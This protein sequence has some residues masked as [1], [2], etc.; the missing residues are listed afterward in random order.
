MN[1]KK[2]P[3]QN[4]RNFL[5]QYNIFTASERKGI[6]ILSAVLLLLM[7]VLAALKFY[8]PQEKVVFSELDKT[9]KQFQELK[10]ADSIAIYSGKKTDTAISKPVVA[11]VFR[12][13]PNTLTD[14]LWLT[15]GISEKQLAVIR[16]YQSKGG[17][18]RTRGDFKKLYTISTE[19]YERLHP[20]IDLPDS[21]S[22]VKKV[23][24]HQQ[25]V[26][27]EKS[28]APVYM[29]A[30]LELEWQQLP[31]IG[32]G[33]AAA[34]VAYREKLGGYFHIEQLLDIKIINDTVLDVIKPYLIVDAFRVRK[35][36]INTAGVFELRHPYLEPSLAKVIVNYRKMHGNYTSVEDIKTLGIMRDEDY[37]RLRPYLKVE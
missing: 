37:E 24:A 22:Y 5:K 35:I 17:V 31:Q 9:I 27:R 8:E 16:K 29:N 19:Q 6:V 25:P 13:N 26:N 18:F 36:N 2:P 10:R 33:R 32:E 15:L 12:F 3:F 4:L 23:T 20:F 34:I 1:R 21:I 11:E 30:A 28:I 7:F 14:S